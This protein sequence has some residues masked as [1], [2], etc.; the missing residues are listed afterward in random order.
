M[1]EGLGKKAYKVTRF[2]WISLLF[3]F[4]WWTKKNKQTAC[5]LVDKWIHIPL[6]KGA[7]LNSDCKIWVCFGKKKVNNLLLAFKQISWV[8]I[9]GP[10]VPATQQSSHITDFQKCT[11]CFNIQA[12]YAL[13]PRRP[14]SCQSGQEKRCNRSLQAW[15]EEPLGT[16]TD[17]TPISKWS[18]GCCLLIGHKN[19]LYYWVEFANSNSW[20]LFVSLYITAIV[21]I[22]ACLV[23]AHAPK[24]CMQSGNFHFD[25]SYPF[26]N[27]VY[28]K[29]KT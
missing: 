21:L 7:K 17:R 6:V 10:F 16:L 14:R 15:V 18:S 9:W 2:D 12:N 4:A 28:P 29:T 5:R 11:V 22:T 26:Q 20:V 19:A 27:T 1:S 8:L 13:N 24:E 25:I 23:L 3:F